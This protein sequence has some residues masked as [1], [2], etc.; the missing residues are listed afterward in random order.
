MQH[1]HLMST[2]VV[3]RYNKPLL[4]KYEAA[5]RNVQLKQQAIEKKIAGRRINQVHFP[6]QRTGHPWQK[7]GAASVL[8][9]C[10]G[11]LW[12]AWCGSACKRFSRNRQRLRQVLLSCE[13][14]CGPVAM[15]LK[16]QYSL[17]Q[18]MPI[19]AFD[20]LDVFLFP[21]YRTWLSICTA[22]Q[23]TM[24]H[25]DYYQALATAQR[26]MAACMDRYMHE[27]Q[28]LYCVRLQNMPPCTQ[29]RVS[30]SHHCLGTELF[31]ERFGDSLVTGFL[32]PADYQAWK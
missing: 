1:V 3:F 6:L 13:M 27:K 21:G 8:L 26:E 2:F 18:F 10:D 29:R 25:A 16:W 32:L 7:Q 22:P 19:A 24:S 9:L 17:S 12:V 20:L 31:G 5:E 14:H 11:L 23:F 15:Y 4:P 28:T 30:S